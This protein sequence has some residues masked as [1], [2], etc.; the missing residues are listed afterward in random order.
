M[1]F[2]MRLDPA[3][4]PDRPM[5]SA[6]D[7]ALPESSSSTSRR[8]GDPYTEPLTV[9]TNPIHIPQSFD[10]HGLHPS[11]HSPS[12]HPPSSHRGIYITAQNVHDRR[13]ESGIDVLH[14]AVALEALYDSTDGFPQ[15]NCHPETRTEMLDALYNWLAGDSAAQPIC[16]LH[17]PAG[18]GKSAIM[19]TLCRRLQDQ[20]RLG[21][22]FFLKRHHPT[23]GNAKALFATLAYQLALNNRDLKALISESVERDPS[24]VGRDM[25]VQFHQL[26]VEPCR[27]FDS[28]PQILLIDGLDECEDEAIQQQML[29]LIGSAARQ[30]PSKFRFLVASRPEAH[31]WDVVNIPSFEGLIDPTNIEQSFSDVRIYLESEFV[32]IHREHSHTMNKV[33]TP[34]PS[35]QSLDHLVQ[36]SSGYFVYASTVIK[37]IDDKYSRPTERLET[38]QNMSP[39]QSDAP[40]EALDQLYHQILSGVPVRF[41][42][43]LSDILQCVIYPFDLAPFQIDLLLGLHPGD[44]R[45]I[46]RGLHSVLSVSDFEFGT[47]SVYHASFLDFLQDQRRSSGFH[48]GLRN[49]VNVTRAVLVGASK[50]DNPIV[51][52]LD[53]L[54][55]SPRNARIT[56]LAEV[57]P[58]AKFRKDTASL[59]RKHASLL[60]QL[61]SQHA[62][63]ARHL[64]RLTKLPTPTCPCCDLCDETVDHY[65]H[66]CPAHEGARRRLYSTSQKARFTENLL[67][68]PALWPDFFIFVQRTRR[69]HSVFGDFPELERDDDDK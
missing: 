46:L 30:Y 38:I 16:W 4:H 12:T 49:R 56:K 1:W 14:R 28:P 55:K 54:R 5:N 39:T 15:P 43:Q 36:K 9:H 69:F 57:M 26:L 35:P 58:L 10:G 29:W 17:G 23:R 42:S 32:R 65:L 2:L 8:M 7:E 19:Q 68:D 20:R 67:S 11:F 59:P 50:L 6:N 27:S 13:G 37:F 41:R 62:P 24:L 66:F 48:V 22:A 34:W 64:H 60:F 52:C 31:I 45:L 47:I 18:A 21:G 3:A 44:T 25:H 33:P 61:R 40:F 63:L 53:M 51:S